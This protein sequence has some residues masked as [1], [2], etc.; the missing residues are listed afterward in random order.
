MQKYISNYIKTEDIP[1]YSNLD[2]GSL[3]KIV[4]VPNPINDGDSANK[5]YVD[6]IVIG[7][8]TANIEVTNSVTFNDLINITTINLKQITRI[9]RNILNTLNIS[10]S[11]NSSN[12]FIESSFTFTLPN[13]ASVFTDTFI[14]YLSSG[15]T[16]V[17]SGIYNIRVTGIIGTNNVKV[18]YTHPDLTETCYL[19]FQISYQ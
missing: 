12:S 19:N 2:L 10:V 5:S 4:N 3:Q 7:G 13:K 6:N 15:N 16:D 17:N 9:S 1:V 8:G 18:T 14:S 11:T